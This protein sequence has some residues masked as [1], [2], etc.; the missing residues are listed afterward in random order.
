KSYNRMY[1]LPFIL[2]MIGL[3]FHWNR[4]PKDFLVTG[5]L[6]FFTGFAI[7]VYLNQAG[8]QPRERDY[9]YAGSFY[10]F[11]IWIGLGYIWVKEQYQKLSFLKAK[12]AAANYAAAGLCLLAVPVLMGSQEWDDHDRGKKTLARDIGRDY[13]ES[14]PPNA[15][16]FSFGDNDTYPLWYAQEVE[17][18][19]PDVRV[20][21]YSLLGTD[22]YINQLRY[23]VNQSAPTDVIFAPEQIQGTTRDVVYINNVPG[24]DPNKTYDL[25][26]MLKKVVAS[27]DP[28]YTN[29]SEDGETVNFLP[30]RKFSVPVDLKAVRAD[31]SVNPGDSVVNSLQIEMSKNKNYLLKNE[32][33][34]LSV[35][36]ANNWKRPI[37]FNSTYEVEDLGIAKYIRQEGLAGRLVPVEN[38]SGNGM[39][40]YNNDLAYANLQ[41]FAYGNAGTPGVYYDEENRRHLNSIRAAHAQL[42]LSLIEA[43]KKD[44]ARNILERFD[45]N[46]Y[47]PN[48]PYG[49]TTNRANQQ[50]RISMSF[51]LACY[52]SGD[53][54]LAGKVEA[55]LKKDLEQQYRYYKSLGD[56]MPDEQL[57]VNAN[58]A[59]QGKPSGLSERQ[60]E[61]AA[62]I[63]ST[64]QM[65]MSI[66]DWKRQFMP[67][68]PAP[69]VEK[70]A[71][72]I[73]GP[74]PR[75]N[76]SPAKK[77]N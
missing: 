38:K 46:V 74:A 33:A 27:D 61:F 34:V 51:L 29:Q 68:N 69:G 3:V 70:S 26:D 2:G 6:F 10:A 13:L 44:S 53:S 41:K 39:P 59:S 64:Y 67:G 24:F 11:A 47:E 5:L 9:A 54:A 8:Y 23:K 65:L 28:K 60:G 56:P 76:D 20:I 37:C 62:D 49:M 32:L 19:R 17:G 31:G 36:A 72:I 52:Q 4:Q 18:I 12:G 42:A 66:G 63:L 58:M 14:C 16:L 25:Y 45:K 48:F 1:M 35:I 55:S 57:A 75:K 43:G 71:P 7:V 15:I 40:F 21:N 30:A 50:D 73:N 77:G 22:W